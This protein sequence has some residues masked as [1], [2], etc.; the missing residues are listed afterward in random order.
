[1]HSDTIAGI[2]V[3]YR[4]SRRAKKLRI[5]VSRRGIAVSVPVGYPVSSARRVV[6]AKREWIEKSLHKIKRQALE[7][8]KKRAEMP[9]IDLDR[10][11]EQLFERL[12]SL[13]ARFGLSYRKAAFRCQKTKWGS[14][15]A[16][17]NISLN[18][19]MVFLPP[20]LQD[21]L[22]LHELAHTVEKNHGPKYWKML[23]SFTGCNAK[24]LDAELNRHKIMFDREQLASYYSA[25]L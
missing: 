21:Y 3:E 4:V 18:V 12:N 2:A 13:A 17:N 19:N 6:V 14:C 11:Q 25:G 7:N 15:S 22:L 9:R 10:A 16:E 24:E 20:H 1:M 23:S 5:S 8:E